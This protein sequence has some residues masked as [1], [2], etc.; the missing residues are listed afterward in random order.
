M[1]FVLMVLLAVLVLYLLVQ[2]VGRYVE[3]RRSRG[4]AEG[5]LSEQAEVSKKR[6]LHVLSRRPWL[7]LVLVLACSLPLYLLNLLDIRLPLGLPPSVVMILVPCAVAM[8]LAYQERGSGGIAELFRPFFVPSGP[9]RSWWLVFS[10]LVI[11][12]LVFGMYLFS[13]WLGLDEAGSF[14]PNV[15]WAIVFTTFFIG[16]IPEEVGWTKYATE[17]MTKR[18]GAMFAGGIIGLTWGLWH[19]IPFL[20]QGHPWQWILAQVALSVVLRMLMV[21]VFNR[22]AGSLLPALLIH[23]STNFYPETLPHRYDD[24]QPAVLLVLTV[25]V[26]AVWLIA[27]RI[28]APPDKQRPSSAGERS[29]T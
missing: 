19:V 28:T 2:A 29:P 7:F 14:S 25:V 12:A 13:V 11:P 26:I 6:Y 24:Y 1:T 15:L 9:R 27:R 17:P 18:Y 22:T 8:A 21:L 23:A 10:I 5:V 3:L 20:A 16:A 4:T